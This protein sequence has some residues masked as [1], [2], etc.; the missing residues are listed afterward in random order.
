MGFATIFNR[1]VR[2]QAYSL[3]EYMLSVM[4]ADDMT[5]LSESAV[6]HQ[7]L[8]YHM[9]DFCLG[10]AGWDYPSKSSCLLPSSLINPAAYHIH[11][12]GCS[13][14]CG[15]L[16]AAAMKFKTTDVLLVQ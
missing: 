13:E 2:R 8:R 14:F 9:D 4:C 3:G 16:R 11:S 5:L 12:N 7:L 1:V 15:S 6:G 10:S